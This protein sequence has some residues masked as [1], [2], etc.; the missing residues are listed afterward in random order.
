MWSP[1]WKIPSA[2]TAPAGS[3]A[4]IRTPFAF[5]SVEMSIPMPRPSRRTTPLITS[6]TVVAGTLGGSSLGCVVAPRMA[7]SIAKSSSCLSVSTT[8][9][10]NLRCSKMSSCLISLHFLPSIVMMRSPG[11]TLPTR[12]ATDPGVTARTN[13]PPPFLSVEKTRPKSAFPSRGNVTVRTTSIAS[14]P[15]TIA[16]TLCFVGMRVKCAHS[17]SPA[18]RAWSAE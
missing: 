4:E 3:M 16:R 6:R 17:G 1:T 12:S 18:I 13:A 15:P 11:K 5:S 2:A 10:C 8:S 7:I 9:D 14:W